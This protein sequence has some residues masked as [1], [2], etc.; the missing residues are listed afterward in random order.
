MTRQR[1]PQ[2][3]KA[4]DY[5]RQTRLA[6]GESRHAE[7]RNKPARRARG[8]RRER[9]QVRQALGVE[10]LGEDLGIEAL[11]ED[12][13]E[14]GAAQQEAAEQVRRPDFSSWGAMALGDHLQNRLEYRANEAGRR[15]FREGYDSAHHREP[16]ARF[17][18]ATVQG[19]GP[20]AE[21]LARRMAARLE[22]G[23]DTFMGRFLADEPSWRARLEAW[24]ASVLETGRG[25]G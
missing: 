19:R 24:I 13:D 11:G 1:D 5:A 8:H 20:V 2:R 4:L 3:E 17:L 14:R 23:P 25:P 22:G 21:P 16:F 15:H 7:R 6:S 18:E 12:R 9:R 10:A